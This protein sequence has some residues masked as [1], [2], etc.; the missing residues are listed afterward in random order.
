MASRRI[1]T[2]MRSIVVDIDRCTGCRACL[3]ACSSAHGDG[4]SPGRARLWIHKDD[5]AAWDRPIVCRHCPDSAC[6]RTCPTG[7][8]S[9][10]AAGGLE[11]DES[12]CSSCGLCVRACPYGAL[13]VDPETLMPMPCDLC[14]GAPACV[15]ACGA[16]GLPEEP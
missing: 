6:V 15:R 4:F 16:G 2:T 1:G 7:A 3:L 13:R 10:K 12:N 8:L 5:L 11:L 9:R 14:H